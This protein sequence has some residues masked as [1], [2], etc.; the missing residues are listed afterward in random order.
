MSVN[1]TTLWKIDHFY[2][3]EAFQW[4]STEGLFPTGDGIFYNVLGIV[5]ILNFLPT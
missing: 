4:V 3:N 2:G 1:Q 5:H